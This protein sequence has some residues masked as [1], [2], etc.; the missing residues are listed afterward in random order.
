MATEILLK[1]IGS[2]PKVFP[3]QPDAFIEAEYVQLRALVSA[4]EG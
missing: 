1:A 3:V 2:L 4:T